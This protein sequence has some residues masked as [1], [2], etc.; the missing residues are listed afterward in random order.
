MEVLR[1]L[2]IHPCLFAALRGLGVLYY[3]L[4]FLLFF[5]V[6]ARRFSV[7]A[8]GYVAGSFDGAFVEHG[9]VGCDLFHVLACCRVRGRKA[10]DS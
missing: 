5:K 1:V 10:A 8:E 7:P 4:G 3:D 6:L 2:L 9:S